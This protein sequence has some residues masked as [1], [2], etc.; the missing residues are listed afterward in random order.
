MVPG[1]VEAGEQAY[2]AVTRTSPFFLREPLRKQLH[3]SQI[4]SAEH[5]LGVAAVIG[6]YIAQVDS[7]SGDSVPSRLSS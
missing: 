3:W 5:T 4:L 6:R 1:S 2:H 7:L